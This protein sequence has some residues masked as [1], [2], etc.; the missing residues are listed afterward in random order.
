MWPSKE[1]L[2]LV[3]E[4]AL[5]QTYTEIHAFLG[6]VGHHRQFIKG[7]AHVAQPLHEHISGEGV[8][9]KSDRG[10]GCL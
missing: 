10:K 4:F 9:K 8:H 1:N 6:F 2:K 7:F 3:V 5:P